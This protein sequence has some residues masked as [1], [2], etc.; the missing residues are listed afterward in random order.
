VALA[1]H[2]DLATFVAAIERLPDDQRAAFLL[3]AEGEL[4]VA[5]IAAVMQSSFE[6]TKSRLRY[7]REKLRG[8]LAEY[9]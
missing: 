4:S 6:T 8:L 3:Q 2:E 1:A 7:A 9:A 5:E